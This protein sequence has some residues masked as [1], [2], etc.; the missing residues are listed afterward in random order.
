M[1]NQINTII[2]REG[3]EKVLDFVFPP[4]CPGCRREVERG[5]C[6]ECWSRLQFIVEPYCWRCGQ[7]LIQPALCGRCLL[8]KP[9]YDRAR[10]ALV[11]DEVSRQLV[12]K[13]KRFD[14]L[15]LVPLLARWM[16]RAGQE[17]LNPDVVLIPVP[18]APPALMATSL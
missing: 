6:A 12:I 18:F 7:P 4:V 16:I 15:D 5:L 3:W 1:T 17:L 13:L 14:R 9:E 8:D 11:Y 2:S 10:S